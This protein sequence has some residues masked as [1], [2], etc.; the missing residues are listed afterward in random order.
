MPASLSLVQER[1]LCKDKMETD[2]AGHLA[3]ACPMKV[4]AGGIRLRKFRLCGLLALPCFL[5]VLLC[6]AHP[7]LSGPLV[8]GWLIGF[9]PA[10]L[11]I[12]MAY[13][14]LRAQKQACNVFIREMLDVIPVPLYVKD[15]DCRY[16]W[17][18]RAMAEDLEIPAEMLIGRTTAEVAHDKEDGM[19]AEQEDR[20][21][22]QG[23][24]VDGERHDVHPLKGH[25][26]HR[27]IMKGSCRGLNGT[28]VV[29]GANFDITRWWTGEQ[30]LKRA[31]SHLQALL[32][33]E[34]IQRQRTEAFIQRLI[35]VMPDSVY[36]RKKG[37]QCLM[38][39]DA[40][41]QNR[42]VDKFNFKGFRHM[43][44]AAMEE[45]ERVLAGEDISR[46]EHST[47]L[48]SGE[49]VFRVIHKRRSVFFDGEPVVVGVE[50]YI[51]QWRIAEREL[52]R[53]AQEDE[54]TG[55]PNRRYFGLEGDRLIERALRYEEKLSLI[56]LDIDFF[57]QIN[58]TYGHNIGDE[59][60]CEMARR[61]HSCLRKSDLPGRWGGEEF[62]ILLPNTSLDIAAY[63]AERLRKGFC[64]TPVQTRAGL[65][66][67][68]F[69]GGGAQLGAGDSLQS[70]IARADAALYQAKNKGRN[71]IECVA[72]DP[73]T[74]AEVPTNLASIP[75]SPDQAA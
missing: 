45:D 33:E 42:S 56:M 1:L 5:I 67:V 3:P 23:A 66:T 71:R 20:A 17:A 38:I 34:T 37:G 27:I 51:T 55:L 22:L 64:A 72:L 40:F 8:L 44:R 57:K 47:R 48:V 12:F 15:A 52:K 18:N 75:R 14:A 21:V 13:G 25:E 69:S 39:N 43:A 63:V 7:V 24:R 16:V 36:I 9:L 4:V 10:C 58:D 29:V 28:P 53:L 35:D 49:E 46:E 68:S 70:L 73:G 19:R 54:L 31:K 65:V 62:V 6:L 2:R 26:R 30:D 61:L 74:S 60:L 59:V 41:A 50:H 11:C 32:T